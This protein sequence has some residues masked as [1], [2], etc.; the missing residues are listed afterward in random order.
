M[1]VKSISK[2]IVAFL[3]LVTVAGAQTGEQV[4]ARPGIA[5]SSLIEG[6]ED[7]GGYAIR[8]NVWSSA[9]RPAAKPEKADPG[10]LSSGF[11]AAALSVGSRIQLTQ[12][13]I[14]NSI[15]MGFPLGDG[16]WIQTDL[17]VIDDSL[18]V[19]ALAATNRA[20]QQVLQQLQTQDDR[21]RAWCEWLIDQNRNL[22]L[23]NYFTSP[24][25]LAN[26]EPYQNIATCT[27][28]LLSLATSGR[29]Q[30]EDGSCR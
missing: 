3:L 8:V 21:L 26:D 1:L 27:Q 18:R 23:A 19:A 11:A 15:K 25:P 30:Q 14:T 9:A 20:D 13:R 4:A 29:L 10:K 6:S 12:R 7:N 2:A 17:N 24:E 28:F 16:F 22:R 5:D